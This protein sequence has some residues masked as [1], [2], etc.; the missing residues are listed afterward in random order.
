MGLSEQVVGSKSVFEGRLLKVRV[1]TVRLQ[2]GKTST[3]EIVQHPGAVAMVPMAD[4]ETVILVRQDRLPAGQRLLEVHA[5]TLD[6]GEEPEACAH[7]EL[8]EE[9]QFRAG[10]MVKLCAFYTAPGYTTEKI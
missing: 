5:G 4:A 10:R 1:D 7:R 3:R 8:A 2:N 9:V 6:P